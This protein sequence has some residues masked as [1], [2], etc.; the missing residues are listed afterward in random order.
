MSDKGYQ[1]TTSWGAIHELQLSYHYTLNED[2]SV[3]LAPPVDLVQEKLR[4]IGLEI[5]GGEQH[6]TPADLYPGEKKITLKVEPGVLM[7][8]SAHKIQEQCRRVSRDTGSKFD[9]YE[10]YVPQPQKRWW[11]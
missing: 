7:K 5:L 1:Y 11:R 8:L 3:E 6:K 4:A 9:I 2:V 10:T